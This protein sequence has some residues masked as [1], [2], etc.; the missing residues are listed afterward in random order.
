MSKAK[1]IGTF[2]LRADG[3]GCGTWETASVFRFAEDHYEVADPT[4]PN[5]DMDL[6][7]MGR[8]KASTLDEVLELLQ[9][10]AQRFQFACLPHVHEARKTITLA[11]DEFNEEWAGRD[12][13]EDYETAYAAK[14]SQIKEIEASLRAASVE[15]EKGWAR[16][17]HWVAQ[18][19][20]MRQQDA[21]A[22]LMDAPSA[23][24][25]S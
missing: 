6:E 10:A 22:S 14:Q 19:K 2:G 13:G 25:P 16:P 1:M 4:H 23:S 12:Q 21:E 15:F 8:F 5:S 3:K 24:T 7:H 17:E 20:K 18:I 9:G 11:W